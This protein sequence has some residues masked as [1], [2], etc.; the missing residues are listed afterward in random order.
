MLCFVSLACSQD[1]KDATPIKQAEVKGT[2]LATFAG[3]CFWCMEKPFD[4]MKGVYSVTSGY[5]GGTLKNPTYAQVS[6]GKTQHLETVQIEYDPRQVSY[7]DLLETFWQQIDPTDAGGQFV[8]RGRQ[9]SSAIFFHSESQKVLAEQ[10]KAWIEQSGRFKK[11]IVTSILA[12]KRFYGAED[13]HQDYYSKNPLRYKIYRFRSGRDAFL[14]KHW[15][16]FDFCWENCISAEKEKMTYRKPSDEVIR[17][18]LSQLAYEVTQRDGTEPPFKNAYWDH[19]QAGIYVDIISGEPLFS[20]TEKFRS[21][22]GWPSFTAPIDAQYIV[23]KKD[24]KLLIQRTEV[25]SKYGDSHLGHV[26]SDGPEPTGLRYCINSAALRFVP[27]EEMKAQGYE[28]FVG[29]FGE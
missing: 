19:K 21:G 22:T 17:S 25:R 1:S 9:Y 18:K 15:Q 2:A 7:R 23:E 16:N 10:S 29:L 14:E 12:Y 11:P 6:G 24:R 26:F 3:G 28:A 13:Y 20:S 4:Q 8:D 5:S 27:K